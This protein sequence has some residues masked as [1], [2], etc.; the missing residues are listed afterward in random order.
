MPFNKKP[1]DS[2][3]ETYEEFKKRT[4]KKTMKEYMKENPK[5]SKPKMAHGDKPKMAHGKKPKMAHGKKPKMYGKPKMYNKKPFMMNPGSKEVDSPGSFKANEPAMMFAKNMPKL[6]DLSGDGKVTK[7]DRL[8]G[9]GAEGF[10]RGMD[11]P[12]MYGKPKLYGKK[13]KMGHK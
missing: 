7:K 2:R 10:E 4:G 1:K 12:K 6:T 5:G 11:K 13:P 3:G 9:A 8:I